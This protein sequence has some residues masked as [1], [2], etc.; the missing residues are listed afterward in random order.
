MLPKLTASKQHCPS[1][2]LLIQLN[3]WPFD[4]SEEGRRHMESMK[5]FFLLLQEFNKL[6]PNRD[7]I[8]TQDSN[9]EESITKF[10]QK[11]AVNS[12]PLQESL[13]TVFK[14]HIMLSRDAGLL[15]HF[16]AATPGHTGI[17]DLTVCHVNTMLVLSCIYHC[18][19]MGCTPQPI[20]ISK[21]NDLVA[22]VY[23]SGSTGLA[24]G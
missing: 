24:K 2:K 17:P 15:Q 22:V 7:I 21:Y 18:F 1:L 3:S 12:Q 13:V 23:T 14:Y 4:P 19:V 10:I 8:V 5:S 11:V 9:L 20:S 6:S 16:V